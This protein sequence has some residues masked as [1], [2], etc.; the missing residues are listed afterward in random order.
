MASALA[1]QL[2]SCSYCL[3]FPVSEETS[4]GHSRQPTGRRSYQQTQ[5]TAHTVMEL[6]ADTAKSPHGDG[7]AS[8]HRR[9]G[10][11]QTYWSCGGGT[12]GPLTK[13][14]RGKK[15]SVRQKS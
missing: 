8:N 14:S 4:Y 3:S 11:L 2:S 6:P 12:S 7:A 1:W 13:R 10:I 15:S 9:Q 5:Q